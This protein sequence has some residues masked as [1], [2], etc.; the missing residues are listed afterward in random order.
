MIFFLMAFLLLSN[1]HSYA[2]KLNI[3]GVE[4]TNE[5]PDFW[6]TPSVNQ[7][8]CAWSGSS[9]A[10]ITFSANNYHA[11]TQFSNWFVNG[12]I[13][14][15]YY[16]NAGDIASFTF[17]ASGRP[18]G[19]YIVQL[20]ARVGTTDY[21]SSETTIYVLEEPSVSIVGPTSGCVGDSISLQAVV[22]DIPQGYTVK[23][24]RNEVAI[25]TET[26]L[27]YNFYV[28]ATP[29]N[30]TYQVG[31][32]YPG[33]T[34][35]LSPTLD[36]TNLAIP[37]VNITSPWSLC[38]G[39]SVVVT[40]DAPSSG[41]LQP[42]SYSWTGPGGTVLTSTSSYEIFT[43][44]PYTVS[45]QFQ[46][47]ACNTGNTAFTVNTI[48]P[49]TLTINPSATNVCEGNQYTLRTTPVAAVPA[50]TLY[51]WYRNGVEIPGQNLD[52]ISET[53][54]TP[55]N[56]TY[57]VKATYPSGCVTALSNPT[58]V[59]VH[60]AP[61]L[62]ITG[63][64]MFCS[65]DADVVLSVNNDHSGSPSFVWY[66]D[67]VNQSVT[68]ASITQND[69]PARE[70]PYIYKVTVTDDAAYGACVVTKEYAVVINPTPSIQITVDDNTPCING[71]ITFTPTMGYSTDFT[72]QWNFNHGNTATSYIYNTSIG[73]VGTY[74]VYLTVRSTSAPTCT[75]VSNIIN[76]TPTAIP[77]TP[78]ISPVASN[79]CE[80]G[81]VTLTTPVVDGGIF[82]WYKNGVEVTGA[83]TRT[84]T[85]VLPSAG[86]YIYT[87]VVRTENSGCVSLTSTPDTIT[88]HTPEVVTISGTPIFCTDPA[89]VTLSSNGHL[90]LLQF[91]VMHCSAQI[92]QQLL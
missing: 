70:Y 26:N 74:P 91:L 52:S 62:T 35:K 30:Y 3:D 15:S 72:Y 41:G 12:V 19:T 75:A 32:T 49:T 14:Q 46:N 18:A 1:S 42:T 68:T 83:T 10:T 11:E 25:P 17:S 37:V 5:I 88:V 29:Q 66:R 22:G 16:T 40:A 13:M 38:A 87:V 39:G 6:I 71:E 50:G 92:Q 8:V 67:D 60:A 45:A 55:G 56:Y 85:E 64:S 59:T 27:S 76:I 43:A 86:T 4:A 2:E 9:S 82:T 58:S 54:T 36:F 89:T 7:F 79:V 69:V 80:G 33:C 65:A 61:E 78:V 63:T 21:Y 24:Y 23:W 47:A 20:V 57:R 51:T 31:I 77:T 81:Q 53:N 48:T 28:P 90:K 73:T 34:E 84:L 44:G